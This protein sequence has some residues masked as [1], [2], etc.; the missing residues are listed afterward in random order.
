MSD[1]TKT[2]QTMMNDLANHPAN[3]Y[4][5]IHPGMP[6]PVLVDSFERELEWII[7]ALMKAALD[8]GAVGDLSMSN[9]LMHHAEK[10]HEIL[11]KQRKART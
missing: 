2:L 7:V 5:A 4:R 3:P 8:T 10:A 6:H 11:L 9:T 1:A